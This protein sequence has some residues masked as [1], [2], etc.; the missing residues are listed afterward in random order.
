M[1]HSVNQHF[2]VVITSRERAELLPVEVDVESVAPG[3]VAGS[4]L[5]SLISAGTELSY[6]YQSEKFPMYPGYAAVFRVEKIGEGVENF[7]IGDVVL[8]MGN[9]RSFQHHPAADVWKSPAGLSP[10]D[11]AFARLMGVSMST[12]TTTTARPPE[13][14]VVTGLGPVGH[15]AAQIFQ[16]CGY[17]VLG[18]DPDATRRELATRGGIANVS[19][20]LPLEDAEWADKTALVLECSG[21]E[22]ATLDA[23]RLVRKRGEVALIGV[24]W[25][26]RTELYAHELLHAVFHRYV[27]LRSG[28]EWEVP[29]GETEFRVGSISANIEGALRWLRSGEV[30][31]SGLYTTVNPRDCQQAYQALLSAQE[32]SLA[33]VFDWAASPS[34]GQ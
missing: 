3:H 29:L 26:R 32:K 18:F 25:R 30:K 7:Q 12:L 11:A 10:S 9:H 27:V 16:A 28:W 20:S 21:H 19:A 24:P 17:T 13:R 34:T 8:A 6:A 23:C 33:I 15:L 2:E 4:T 22:Q 14:V 5:A 31:V 1:S